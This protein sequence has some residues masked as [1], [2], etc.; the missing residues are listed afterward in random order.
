MRNLGTRRCYQL[1]QPVPPPRGLLHTPQALTAPADR[2]VRATAGAFAVGTG[3]AAGSGWRRLSPR[4]FTDHRNRPGSPPAADCRHNPPPALPVNHIRCS[5]DH[6]PA[7][8]RDADPD[9]RRAAA[10]GRPV[11]ARGSHRTSTAGP[12]LPSGICQAR[13][14]RV[15]RVVVAAPRSEPVTEPEEVGLVDG[16]YV[17]G[18]LDR[19]GSRNASQYRRPGCGLP[20]LPAASAPQ[21]NCLSRL[22]T[23]PART[24]VNAAPPPSRAAA[25]DSG[26]PWVATTTL[27]VCAGARGGAE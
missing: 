8:G 9:I 20:P 2:P 7:W 1:T 27:P 19:A 18:V 3:G 10:V 14:E 26:P 22:D 5:A 25:H 24:P 11:R 15:Q 12:Q 6:R 13:V 16:V 17:L 4:S 23:R 21:S